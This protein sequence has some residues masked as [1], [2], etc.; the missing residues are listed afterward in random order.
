[1]PGTT[2][3]P[4][5]RGTRVRGRRRAARPV[6]LQPTDGKLGAAR[7]AGPAFPSRSR[8][9]CTPSFFTPCRG[10]G[11]SGDR[12]RAA[13]ARKAFRHAQPPS[14]VLHRS[15]YDAN[16]RALTKFR[17]ALAP[18]ISTSPTTWSTS[19]GLGE[20]ASA[21]RWQWCNPEGEEHAFTLR[22]HEA[23]RAG[24]DRVANFLARL[25]ASAGATRVLVILRPPL[26]V[27][28]RAPPALQ[29]AGRGAWCRRRS[30]SRSTTCRTGSTQARRQGGRRDL[31]RATSRTSC[32]AVC[33]AGAAR[34]H[35]RG[36]ESRLR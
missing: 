36:R 14:E 34:R 9:V 25:R 11:P 27:L 6:W 12:R 23:R 21:A 35:G 1:M 32:D 33:E 28:V 24:Q 17:V 18:T 19:S 4:Q 16:G 26:P 20:P 2:G 13:N 30:C 7:G 15:R 10:A 31:G 29:Q 8:S 22:G 3:P 5:R